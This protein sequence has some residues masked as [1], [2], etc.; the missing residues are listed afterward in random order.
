MPCASVSE[1]P[2]RVSAE[3]LNGG[4]RV[5]TR[6]SSSEVTGP[7]PTDAQ[8]RDE[9]ADH[10]GSASHRGTGAVRVA[11]RGP[12]LGG[13]RLERPGQ[14]DDLRA[15]RFPEAVRQGEAEGGEALV[16]GALRGQGRRLDRHP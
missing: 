7:D 8:W 16:P 15:L 11:G 13:H 5:E 12:A 10:R 6:P 14:P 3:Y 4:L 9:L 2:T 1:K